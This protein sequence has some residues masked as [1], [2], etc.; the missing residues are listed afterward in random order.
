M[1]TDPAQE[2]AEFRGQ[3][4]SRARGGLG[5]EVDLR[6]EGA[7]GVPLKK[8]PF[9]KRMYQQL[10]SMPPEGGDSAGLERAQGPASRRWPTAGAHQGSQRPCGTARLTADRLGPDRSS[11]GASRRPPAPG[12]PEHVRRSR[13]CSSAWAIDAGRVPE[14]ETSWRNFEASNIPEDHPARSPLGLRRLRRA[15]GP[16]C[17]ARNLARADQAKRDVEALLHGC[18]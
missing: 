1:T 13:T 15:G 17:C 14:V 11:P 16:S 18:P 2:I 9:R 10:G 4:Y 6:R 7:A 5:P 3:S 8:V 12:H